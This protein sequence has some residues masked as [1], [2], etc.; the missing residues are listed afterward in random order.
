MSNAAGIMEVIVIFIEYLVLS[1]LCMFK[2]AAWSLSW[3]NTGE[4]SLGHV[5][6]AACGARVV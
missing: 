5:L 2:R 1:R 6:S 3:Q 4:A